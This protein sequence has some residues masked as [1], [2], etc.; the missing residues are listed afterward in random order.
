MECR[1]LCEAEFSQRSL[2]AQ[3]HPVTSPLAVE[4][5]SFSGPPEEK[6]LCL[7]CDLGETE[8]QVHFM[9]SCFITGDMMI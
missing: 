4:T 9:F 7:L 3:L 6:I 8:D 5:G 1:A 2:C